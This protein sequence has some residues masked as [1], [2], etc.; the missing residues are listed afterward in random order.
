VRDAE[1]DMQR[2]Q[3]NEV[4][5]GSRDGS[6]PGIVAGRQ[7]RLYLTGEQDRKAVR[8]VGCCRAVWNAALEQRRSAWRLARRG[9]WGVEQMA[10]LPGLKRSPGFEWLAQD[11]I[12]QSLQQTLRDLDV[13]YQRFL[14]GAARRPRFKV[15]GRGESFRLPQGRDLPVRRLNRRWAQVRLPKLGWCRFRLSRPLGGEVRHATVSRD[16]FGWRVSFC[17]SLYRVPARPNGGAAVGIDRGVAASVATSTGELHH[18]PGLPAGQARRLRRLLRKAGRR[19]TARRHRPSTQRKRSARHQRTL[20]RTAK[21]RAREARIRADFLHK[22]SSDLAKSHGLVAIE[23][24]Q[25]KNMTRSAAGTLSEPG[26]RVAQ[27]RG[28]NRAIL[29]QGWG[30]LHRQLSYK[31]SW[32]GSALTVVPAAYSSQTCSVCGIVDAESRESQARFRC[33]A[34][35]HAEHA[36]VNAARVILARAVNGQEDGGRTWPLQRGEPSRQQPGPR[37]AN[38]RRKAA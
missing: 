20:D 16:A 29:A 21:L 26:E 2:Q 14:T 34:C 31:T 18:C 23:D 36:D 37:T 17:V 5:A 27:K 8:V 10:E 25:V 32:Y 13:A 1:H 19:E 24:L 12:A 33:T 28:L 9:V 11:G 38:P 30:E 3:V 4:G 35:G 6:F 15:K 7:Y 22:L